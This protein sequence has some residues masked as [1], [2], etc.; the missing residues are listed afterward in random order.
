MGA[1]DHP[2]S[3]KIPRIWPEGNIIIIGGGPSFKKVNTNILKRLS[4]EG[5]IRVIG[6]NKAYKEIEDGR[7]WIHVMTFGDDPFYQVFRNRSEDG[8]YTF[9]GIR[10][11][12]CPSCQNDKG[13]KYVAHD[14]RKHHGITK[15]PKRICWNK[16]TGGATINLAYHFGGPRSNIF[17]FGFDMKKGKGGASHWHAG[18]YEKN[19]DHHVKIPFP[20]FMSTI[21]HIAR[22]AKKLKLNIYNVNMDSAINDFEKIPFNQ[23][24]SMVDKEKTTD[25]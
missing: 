11:G 7:E 9:P 8:L 24:K 25:E 21:P 10:V 19:K 18:Y 20:R 14:D 1:N 17:L 2:K 15:H 4:L 12:F 13:V 22:D 5:K 6:C 23:F 16:N 3:W